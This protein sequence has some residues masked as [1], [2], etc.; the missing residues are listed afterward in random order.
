MTKAVP[1]TMNCDTFEVFLRHDV[2]IGYPNQRVIGNTYL[3]SDC[4]RRIGL[5]TPRSA[6]TGMK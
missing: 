1:V 2:V 3:G 6:A 5:L 4:A